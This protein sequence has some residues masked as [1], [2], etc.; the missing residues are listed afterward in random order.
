MKRLVFTVTTDLTYDQRMI[1][2]CTSL[3]QAGYSVTLVGTK[4]R[5]S[6]PLK[7][8]PFYQKRISLLFQ[9]GK[10]FYA[11]YNIRLFFYLL[12]KKMDLLCAIDL[13]TIL[14]VLYVSKLRRKKRV[15]DAHELFCE[16]KE[17]VTRPAI[18]RIWKAIEKKAVPQ[19][20]YGY[21]V[22]APIAAQ[23]KEMYA[24]NYS[25]IA[26]M[27]VLRPL[28]I[29]AKEEKF[30]LYQGAVNEG[31]SFETLIPAM[32]YVSA[33]LYIVGDGNYMQQAR[34][35]VNKEGLETKIIFKGKIA[36][37]E[38]SLF[39]AQAWIGITL[40]ENKGLSNYLSLANRFFDYLHAGVPQLCVDYPTYQE[41]NKIAPIAVLIKDLSPE[42]IAE[43]LNGLLQDSVL[44]KKLQDN[45]LVQREQLNWQ[46]E[47]KKLFKFYEAIFTH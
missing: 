32:R 20:C 21:T 7:Q 4:Y 12:F 46:A 5:H 33:K 1:R 38:L 26:N 37:D 14:P 18:Y 34:E 35:L 13:D 6:S 23:F 28:S 40:F 3:A 39:T 25:C 11:E 44:Y 22:N 19:F 36:P 45:C 10:L 30:I 29:P 8:Q 17:V 15:Y 16:M 9:K 47:E 24:V 42:S 2:I 41:I 27:P 43:N 31:R